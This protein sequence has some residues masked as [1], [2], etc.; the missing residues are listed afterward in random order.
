MEEAARRFGLLDSGR[1]VT[2]NAPQV[3]RGNKRL[4]F[5]VLRST[6]KPTARTGAQ[7]GTSGRLDG[8]NAVCKLTLKGRTAFNS[9]KLF[10][11]MCLLATSRAAR[12]TAAQP[13]RESAQFFSGAG[14][15]CSRRGDRTTVMMFST[16]LTKQK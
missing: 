10:R 9:C 7:P 15:W 11:F 1:L 2:H 8:L 3:V 4:C 12:G 13:A 16:Q 6:T 14:D 5:H